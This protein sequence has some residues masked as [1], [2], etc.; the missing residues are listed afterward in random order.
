M[1]KNGHQA[2]AANA[3]EYHL[4]QEPCLQQNSKSEKYQRFAERLPEQVASL[5]T[6][7]QT[8]YC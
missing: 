2:G 7:K 6:K 1:K 3:C 8:N 4:I 5:L